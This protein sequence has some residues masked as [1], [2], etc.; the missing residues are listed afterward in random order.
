MENSGPS[1]LIRLSQEHKIIID[2]IAK[3]DRFISSN[4]YFELGQLI[5]SNYSFMEHDIEKH[6][7]L[8]ETTIFPAALE[9]DKSLEMHKL[10]EKLEDQHMEITKELLH[11]LK[12]IKT[13]QWV[14]YKGKEEYIERLHKF[15]NKLRAHIKLELDELYPSIE[16]NEEALKLILKT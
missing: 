13:S 5:K 10:I 4:S 2:F 7:M 8:E 12:I 14:T 16:S 15:L 6:F 1:K 3:F 9:S 11:I